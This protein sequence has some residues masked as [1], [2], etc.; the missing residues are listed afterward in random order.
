L[1]DDARQYRWSVETKDIGK[2]LVELI[3]ADRS[4]EGIP[5]SLRSLYVK[6]ATYYYGNSDTSLASTHAITRG[7][8]QG[9]LAATRLNQVRSLVNTLQNLVLAAKVVWEPI[10]TNNDFD[11]AAQAVL[12]RAV[13]EYYWRSRQVAQ[14]GQRALEEAIV[15]GEGFVFTPWDTDL[16]EDVEDD[17][18][19]LDL[20]ET[21]NIAGTKKTG[22]LRYINISTWNVIRN[23]YARSFD[24]C[25]WF[26]IEHTANKFDIIAKLPEEK[27]EELT[28]KIV[29][30]QG[31]FTERAD[32]DV[33]R[34]TDDDDITVYYAFHKRTAAMP[35]G[36]EVV[37]I[38]GDIV[39]SDGPLSY[40]T[41]P[42]YR[43]YAAEM[44]NTPYAYTPFF[45]VLGLQELLDHL[46]TSIATNQTTF[47]T[48]MVAV[49]IGTDVSPESFGGVKLLRYPAGGGVPS[50]LQLTA[51]PPELF[52]HQGDLIRFMEQLFGL[53]S[54][55]RGEAVSGEQSGSALALLQAQA[56]QQSS[57][58]EGAYL[59]FVQSLGTGLIEI[60]R[61]KCPLPRRI[62]ITGKANRALE[63]QETYTGDSFSK[64][65]R[66]EV[67][68]GNP[69]SQT[70]A[71]R[72]ELASMYLELLGP[73]MVPEQ[74]E[75]VLTTGRLEPLT[76][77]L[78]RQLLLARHENERI[79]DGIVPPV[80]VDDDHVLHMRT[81]AEEIANPE[82][83]DKPEALEAYSAHMAEHWELYVTADPG[84]LVAMGQQPPP[85]MAP[86]APPPGTPGPPP[87]PE[88][89]ASI[90]PNAP[91]LP[92]L[93]NPPT[94][95]STGEQFIPPPGATVAP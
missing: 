32:I 39:L 76:Q 90:A 14:Y 9:E 53:N 27:R 87:G 74:M 36:R 49:P 75:Q 68:V 16:G 42:L 22:D 69:M 79:V 83:R 72:K 61:K 60:I 94:D 34:K 71:G 4:N 57:V 54:V 24:E 45:E 18:R 73:K 82:V 44:F 95:P 31:L 81:H 47:G 46:E 5:A 52:R 78:Q 26:I 88:A 21:G 62:A 55:V 48:Q 25:Q 58:L 30:A 41:I 92:S 77:G 40:D 66:V 8:E 91:E 23:P 70:A 11:S 59:R 17:A 84:R 35:R 56:K 86:P 93:P 7:G 3:E 15:F 13:L 65:N 12:A 20:D 89:P 63:I 33:R 80:M 29:G 1:S 67:D 6:A 51:T 50:A 10:A 43:V 28:E 38:N 19:A 85:I 2:K 64:I 37:F